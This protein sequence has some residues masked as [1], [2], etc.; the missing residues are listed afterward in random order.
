[1]NDISVYSIQTYEKQISHN[2][3]YQIVTHEV[4]DAS[5]SNNTLRQ[6]VIFYRRQFTCGFFPFEQLIGQQMVQFENSI[7][8]CLH[9]HS[10]SNMFFDKIFEANCA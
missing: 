2:Y 1:M 10:L 6:H 9:H 5:F 3:Y 7:L 8:E 4:C